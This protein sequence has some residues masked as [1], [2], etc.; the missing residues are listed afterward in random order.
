MANQEVARE[1]PFPSANGRV[2]RHSG[3]TRRANLSRRKRILLT[4]R[5]GAVRAGPGRCETPSSEGPRRPRDPHAG[6]A[7]HSPMAVRAAETI[8]TGSESALILPHDHFT[9]S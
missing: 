8:T 4:G 1:R 6:P 5:V 2:G 3:S 9:R 7:G